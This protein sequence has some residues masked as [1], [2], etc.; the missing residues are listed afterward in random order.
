MPLP[1]SLHVKHTVSYLPAP[2][3]HFCDLPGYDAELTPDQIRALAAA[4]L[5]AADDCE[6]LF[7]RTR[8]YGP[9]RREYP[10]AQLDAT[11]SAQ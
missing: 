7:E 8:W 5:Q 2:L 9:V 1:K 3:V 10:L 11:A 4:M 6:A